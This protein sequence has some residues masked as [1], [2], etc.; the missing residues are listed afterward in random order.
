MKA[1]KQYQEDV[2]EYFRS[3]GLNASTDVTVEGVRT[4]HDVDVLVTSHYVGFDITWVVECKRWKKPVNKLHVL[5][6]REIV[7]DV[8]A[9]RGILLSESGF[10]SGAMEAANLTNIQVTSLENLRD[11]ADE[12]IYAMRLRDLYDRTGIC[13]DRYWDIPKKK[14]IEHGLRSNVGEPGYSGA[15]ITDMCTDLLT[16]AFRGVYPFSNED[17]QALFLFGKDKQFESAR[18]IVEIV[19]NHLSELEKKLDSYEIVKS[20]A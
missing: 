5:G 13:K 1:W 16:R 17:M 12:S 7:S 8:G 10:Q 3:I 19:E 6:L 20:K 11:S 4:K 2:A 18:E 9:D 14:R 15:R